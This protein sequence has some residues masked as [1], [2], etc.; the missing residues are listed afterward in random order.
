MLKGKGIISPLQ[1]NLLIAIGKLPEV[2]KFYL[3]GGTALA[4][5]YL[6]HRVS[7]D[8]D[9]FTPEKSLIIP[10]SRSIEENL[11]PAGYIIRVIRKFES[12]VE[13]VVEDKGESVAI[14]I[15]QESPF[16]FSDPSP[17]ELGIKVNNYQDIIAD[18]VLAYFGRWEYRDAVDLYFILQREQLEHIVSLAKQ[19]DPGFDLYWFAVSLVKAEDFPD[20]ISQWPVD[21][22]IEVSAKTIKETFINLARQ[23]MDRIKGD[24]PSL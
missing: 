1:K 6:G 11:I 14:H 15:S 23:I 9:I 2:E 24:K 16:R 5:F 12:F 7:Y 18:K 20:D 19:K 4:E 8:L 22:L 21:M 10:F 3:S 17:S 13:L